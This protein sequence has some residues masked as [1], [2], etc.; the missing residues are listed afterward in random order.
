M[1]SI[2]NNDEFENNRISSAEL[3]YFIN[4]LIMCKKKTK[5][6]LIESITVGGLDNYRHAELRTPSWI[7]F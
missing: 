1:Q 6:E 2:L 4:P 3:R 5:K 7:S